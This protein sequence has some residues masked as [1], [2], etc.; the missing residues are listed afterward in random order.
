MKI[1]I[2][3]PAY[4]EE[5]DLPQLF[6]SIQKNLRNVDHSVVV[7]DDGST[8]RTAEIAKSSGATLL[9]HEKNRGLGAAIRTGF[10]HVVRIADANDVVVTM[11]ADNSHDPAS[12]LEMIK[13]IDEGCDVVIA[14]RYC[15]GGKQVGVGFARQ[16]LSR[17]INFIF[18]VLF[19]IKGVRDYTSGFRAY[20]VKVIGLYGEGLIRNSGFPCMAEILI[21]LS[22]VGAKICEIPLIL[23]YDFKKGGSKLRYSKIFTEY[24]QLLID[25]KRG[26]S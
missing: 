9:R 1:F 26:L 21:K 20:R 2:L 25:L 19:P 12:V 23:R 7:V 5:A 15:P 18:Q 11:D 14:S 8:D 24:F 22:A 13:K 10:S 3:L 4:N 6:S 16:L 17:G